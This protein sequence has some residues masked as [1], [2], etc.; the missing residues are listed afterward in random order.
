MKDIYLYS[1]V[2]FTLIYFS[3][4]NCYRFNYS[5]IYKAAKIISTLITRKSMW[6]K[7]V[8]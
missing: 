4:I 6:S 8:P 3:Y 1:I 2:L 5:T 7:K